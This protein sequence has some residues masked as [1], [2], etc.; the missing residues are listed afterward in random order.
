MPNTDDE[1]IQTWVIQQ[2][3]VAGCNFSGHYEKWGW[4]LTEATQAALA[5]RPVYPDCSKE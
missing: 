3:K 4:P 5:D 2:S 1:R